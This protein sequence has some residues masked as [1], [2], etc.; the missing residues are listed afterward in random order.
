MAHV[1]TAR[2]T[3]IPPYEP[4]PPPYEPSPQATSGAYY[5]P[6]PKRDAEAVSEPEPALQATSGAYYPPKRDAVSEPAI[7]AISGAYYP[8]KA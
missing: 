4:A 3:N 6:K 2:D 5:P 7:Q 1:H 8:D